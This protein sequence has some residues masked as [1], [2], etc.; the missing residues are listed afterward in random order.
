LI[1]AA[2]VAEVLGIALFFW[3]LWTRIRSPR[4]AAEKSLGT[5]ETKSS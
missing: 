3:N 4:E 5:G 2:S 1:F